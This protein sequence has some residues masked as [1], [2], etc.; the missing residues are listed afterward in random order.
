[1]SPSPYV[2]DPTGGD[3]HAEAALLRA[4]GSVTPVEL[5]GGVTAWSIGRIDLVRRLLADP[6]V[7]KDPGRHWRAWRNGDIPDD[8]PLNPRS[9]AT[10][11]STPTAPST[12][13]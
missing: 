9:R 10:T 3:L 5:P 12:A 2:L 6:R 11:W 8:W 4:R 1:M 7:S 13:G